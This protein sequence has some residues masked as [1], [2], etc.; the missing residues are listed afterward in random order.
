MSDAS[1]EA[2]AKLQDETGLFFEMVNV[3]ANRLLDTSC[4]H[5]VY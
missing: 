3:D 1:G 2:L 5:E 4:G